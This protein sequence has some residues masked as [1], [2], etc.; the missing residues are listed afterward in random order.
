MPYWRLSSFYFFYFGALGVLVPYWGLYL[1]DLGFDA[2]AIGQLMAVPL[3]TKVVAPYAWGWLGDHLGQRMRIVRL[4]SLLTSL[5][6]LGVFFTDG[7]WPLLL[8][9]VL[10]SF[11]WNAV[12]PQFEVVTFRYLGAA[13]ARYA[14]VRVWGSVGFILT[15]LLLGAAV[16]RGGP[17]VILPVLFAL[18]SAIWLASLGVTDPDPGAHP[19]QQGSILGV[20]RQ[21]AVLAFFVACFLMQAGHGAYYAFY[22]IFMEQIGYSKT[23]IGGL[24]ALGVAAEV[25]VFLVMHHLLQRFGASWALQASLGIAALRW[26]LV[27]LFPDSLGLML[28]A[29]LF[30]AATFGVFHASAIHLVHHYFIGRHQGRGQALYSSVSFGAGGSIGSLFAGLL[31]D[32]AGPLV[33]F[34]LSA[35][36]SLLA[37]LIAWRWVDREGAP[38]AG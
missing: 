18:Y 2:L 29:Q 34:L 38:G 6:F 14:R 16:D 24:W 35:L 20:L 21:P 5:V 9:M 7:F 36:L 25:A 30:H 22:S 23:L 11:F 10:F 19:A 4:G 27:G 32:G 12:L 17:V 31:W 33:T 1:K 28:L 26:L 15:V 8:V 3:A 13:V 37:W